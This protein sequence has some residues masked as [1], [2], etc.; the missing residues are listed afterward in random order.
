MEI[1]FLPH[2]EAC[3]LNWI[4]VRR[5]L[6]AS[7]DLPAVLDVLSRYLFYNRASNETEIPNQ[8]VYDTLEQ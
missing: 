3:L 7:V 2:F 5:R 8:T 4:D 6:V 1:L